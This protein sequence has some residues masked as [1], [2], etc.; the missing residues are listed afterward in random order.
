MHEKRIYKHFMDK[1]G[2][3]SKILIK[4]VD[5]LIRKSN[6]KFVHIISEIEGD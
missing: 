4:Y 3:D 1:L 6:G 2:A 5:K